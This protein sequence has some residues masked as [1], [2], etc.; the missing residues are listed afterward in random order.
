M[1]IYKGVMP[2]IFIQLIALGAIAYWPGLA[3]W[4]PE[5]VYGDK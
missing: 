3:T 5:L 4:L 1:Q 2:F